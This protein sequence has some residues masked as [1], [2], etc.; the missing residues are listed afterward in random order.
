MLTLSSLLSAHLAILYV[1]FIPGILLVLVSM[2]YI[3]KARIIVNGYDLLIVI[4][5]LCSVALN[6]AIGLLLSFLSITFV[7]Y[8]FIIGFI[9]LA[10]VSALLYR[11]SELVNIKI[12]SGVELKVLYVI[13]AVFFII[14][15]YN[16]GLIDI[17]ADSWWHMAYANK[18]AETSHYILERHHLTGEPLGR[19]IYAPIWHLQLAFIKIVSSQEIPYIWHSLAPWIVIVTLFSYYRLAS[20]LVKSNWV[21]LLSVVFFTILLGGINSYFR[22]SPWPGNVSYIFLYLLMYMTFLYIDRQ[23]DQNL[24]TPNFDRIYNQILGFTRDKYLVFLIFLSVIVIAG[25]HT[26]QL[27]W[28]LIAFFGYYLFIG[29]AVKNSRIRQDQIQKDYSVLTPIISLIIIAY[30][31]MVFYLKGTLSIKEI[32]DTPIKYISIPIMFTS[33][34][35]FSKLLNQT[36]QNSRLCYTLCA[37]FSV[38]ALYF[39]IDWTHL[40]ALFF[41]SI[42]VHEVSPHLPRVYEGIIPGV[43]LSLPSWSHQLRWGLLY[44][45][46]LSIPVAIYLMLMRRDRGSYFLAS[47]AIIGFLGIVSPYYFTALTQLIPYNSMYRIHL[48]IFSPIIFSL[49]YAHVWNFLKKNDQV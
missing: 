10:L 13:A 36:K 6:G 29:H 18:I 14:M 34:W 3:D 1:L 47:G 46:V 32:F 33:I 22:V 38:I 39:I 31:F 17:L 11:R 25:V 23:P 41:R 28:Y 7:N 12:I 8:V 43:S 9:D 37:V 26:A 49:F 16:G 5:F 44:S 20:V 42:E 4:A 30:L 45:G 35:L 15:S 24:Q 2:R 27:I 40:G 48:I 21:A 19:I